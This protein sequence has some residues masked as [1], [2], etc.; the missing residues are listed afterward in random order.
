MTAMPRI[1]QR[2]LEPRD[3]AIPAHAGISTCAKIPGQAR[4]DDHASHYPPFARRGRLVE[5]E[6][7]AFDCR[8]LVAGRTPPAT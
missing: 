7:G 4:D 1:D 3:P 5:L 2:F 6:A 8:A